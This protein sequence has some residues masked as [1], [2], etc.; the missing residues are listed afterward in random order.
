LHS[1]CCCNSFDSLYS[2]TSRDCAAPPRPASDCLML[3]TNNHGGVAHQQHVTTAA[4]AACSC[5]ECNLLELRVLPFFEGRTCLCT[6]TCTDPPTCTVPFAGNSVGQS[7]SRDSAMQQHIADAGSIRLRIAYICI[8]RRLISTALLISAAC[9][10]LGS[11]LVLRQ[12]V[13]TVWL[14][15]GRRKFRKVRK[16]RK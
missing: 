13:T 12:N 8:S 7:A 11:S 16:S 10:K 1:L 3:Q 6:S 4:A 9:C 2:D 15:S 5:H 14:C